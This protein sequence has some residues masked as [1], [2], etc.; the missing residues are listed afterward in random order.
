MADRPAVA[1]RFQRHRA[2]APSHERTARQ[3]RPTL[4]TSA[5]RPLRPSSPAQARSGPSLPAI[6]SGPFPVTEFL[7]LRLAGPGKIFTFMMLSTGK[8]LRA[9]VRTIKAR[10]GGRMP[11]F[12]RGQ[13]Q[14]VSE[15]R[16]E[17][18]KARTASWREHLAS[19][20]EPETA[21]I[22]SA[23]LASYLTVTARRDASL[24]KVTAEFL[25]RLQHAGYSVDRC[26]ARL[27]RAQRR[28]L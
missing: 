11:G 27:K 10:A 15:H 5:R 23:L 24:D 7:P 22:A 21:V 4:F 16:R 14:R 2:E 9:A 13:R 20:G 18:A 3:I 1:L 6:P 17:K 25:I 12:L 28:L 19:H 26:T 8:D